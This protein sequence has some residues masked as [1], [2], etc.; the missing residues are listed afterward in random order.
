[1][2]DYLE[3]IIACTNPKLPHAVGYFQERE[4]LQIDRQK[5]P[6]NHVCTW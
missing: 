3:Q 6:F 4:S 5:N 2:V 1:M